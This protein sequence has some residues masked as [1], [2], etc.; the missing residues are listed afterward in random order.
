MPPMTVMTAIA[1]VMRRLMSRARPLSFAMS[2]ILPGVP[3][4]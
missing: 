2:V 4:R 1:M 3:M